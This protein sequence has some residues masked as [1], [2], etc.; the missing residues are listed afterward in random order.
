MAA[1]AAWL[2]A[3]VADALVR[4]PQGWGRPVL[5]VR[6]DEQRLYV[7]EAGHA[8]E[9][10]PVSTAA[11]G[12]GNR[13]G[14]LQTPSGL[15][16]VAQRIGDGAPAGA[17]FR[18]RSDTGEVAAILTDPDAVSGGDR[19]TSRI[20]WLEGL[21]P[22]INQGGD[23]DSFARY[24]YI[25]GTDEEGRI[26]SPASHGCIRMRNQDLIGLFPRVPLHSLVLILERAP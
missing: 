13:D 21:E 11:R 23:V 4:A 19:I 12:V 8:P 22:G 2:E 3:V 14:S 10:F 5:I 6:A 16:R 26:G 15:H 17:V 9:A 7:W 24:I 18:G 1:S 20:L 25:H